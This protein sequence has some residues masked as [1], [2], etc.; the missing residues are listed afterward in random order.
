MDTQRTSGPTG[1]NFGDTIRQG[2]RAA[3]GRA[4]GYTLTFLDPT[5]SKRANEYERIVNPYVVIGRNKDC[6]I[7]YDE[8]WATVS[9]RHAIIR[10]HG[11]D[12][13]LEHQG[14]NPTY[15]NGKEI[16]G[17][18]HL[19]S[20]DELR[21]SAEGP[22]LRFTNMDG[23]YVPVSNPLGTAW[24]TL[25]PFRYVLLMLVFSVVGIIGFIAYEKWCGDE[26]VPCIKVDVPKDLE[27]FN[28]YIYYIDVKK[29]EVRLPGGGGFQTFQVPDELNFKWSG[30]GF[31]TDDDKFI[32][33][34]HVV[35]PWVYL[36]EF[37]GFPC[38]MEGGPLIYLNE[39]QQRGGQVL[40]TFEAK[41]SSHSFTFTS[42][43]LRIDKSLDDLVCDGQ[44]RVANPKD[45]SSDWAILDYSGKKSNV[46][47]DR[48]LSENLVKGNLVYPI[49]YPLGLHISGGALNPIYSGA[50]TISQAGLPNKMIYSG[51][52]VIQPG[53]SGGPVFYNKGDECNPNWVVI[54]IVQGTTGINSGFG[55]FVPVKWVQ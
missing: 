50:S 11:D 24:K 33:S 16:T 18:W 53:V 3:S 32:T 37:Q 51:G 39:N 47:I 30:T 25:G 43:A 29:V 23:G 52:G 36:S 27:K 40:V 48:D 46:K 4:R 49:G 14:M 31:L 26:I 21:F 55:T 5:R 15:V 44:F 6:D 45:G 54:G 2:M 42:D 38:Q 12:F 8:S 9:G 17:Q 41:S 19:Q 34:R 1:R 10:I 7:S 13:I 35:Q 20:G 28:D 22:R